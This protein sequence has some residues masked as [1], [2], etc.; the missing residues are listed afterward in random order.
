MT[1]IKCNPNVKI[2]ITD[3]Y[4]TGRTADWDL[5]TQR[6]QQNCTTD[7]QPYI[8]AIDREINGEI[9]IYW[10]FGGWR[11]NHCAYVRLD[12]GYIVDGRYA[13]KTRNYHTPEYE[14]LWTDLCHLCKTGTIKEE[15]QIEADDIMDPIF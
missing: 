9:L 3:R 2:R 5:I 8:E 15:E 4:D 12:N 14:K 10:H 7:P 6:I 1:A 11:I 13:G